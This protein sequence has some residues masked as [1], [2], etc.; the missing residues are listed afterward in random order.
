VS[1][2]WFGLTWAHNLSPTLG[3]GISPYVA[4]RSQNTKLR[5][6][7]SAQDASN[8]ATV[9]NVSREFDYLHYR[10]LAKLGLSG[11]RDSLTYGVSLTTP[12][13]GMFGGGNLRSNTTVVD[14]SGAIG[15]LNGASYQDKL[16]SHYRSPLG[17]AAGASY[18]FGKMR[19]H[20]TVD[21]FGEVSR[22]EVLSGDP[23]TIRTSSGDSTV[24]PIVDQKLDA[25]LN[26]GIGIERQAE[27]ESD[28]LRELPHR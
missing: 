7:S 14:E 18:G 27:R 3:F 8:T 16:K 5:L 13:L 4:V 26:W 24:T 10:L 23:Y 25:V 19:L 20:G 12:G 15:P 17:V 6:F 9:A 11:V 21:W 1:E 22:Y 2:N 28:R